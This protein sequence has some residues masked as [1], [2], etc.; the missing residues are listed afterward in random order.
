[1]LRRIALLLLLAGAPLHGA[2]AQQQTAD[3]FV[4]SIYVLYQ[5]ADDR[6][7]ISTIWDQPDRYFVQDLA[8][9]IKRDRERTPHGMVG[10]LD[11]D[12]FTADQLGQVLGHLAIEATTQGD[13]AKVTVE[14]ERDDAEH[15]HAR[16]QIDLERVSA[17][18]RVADITWPGSPAAGL[19]LRGIFRVNN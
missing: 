19:T 16:I 6:T 8:N 3:E 7:R 9:A 15:S 4:A 13:R 2:A 1:M 11:F 18:W 17:G 10:A 5:S 12:P 14:F